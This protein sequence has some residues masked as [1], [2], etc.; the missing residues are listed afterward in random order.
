MTHIFTITTLFVIHLDNQGF[1]GS[2]RRWAGGWVWVWVGRSEL[3]QT[4]GKRL[5]GMAGGSGRVLLAEITPP[6]KN[7]T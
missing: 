5:L 6:V 2:V 4:T 7:D 3:L 1:Y